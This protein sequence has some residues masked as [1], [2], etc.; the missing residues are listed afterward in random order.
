MVRYDWFCI[1]WRGKGLL[2]KVVHDGEDVVRVVGGCAE[3]GG[4]TR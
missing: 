4:V 3:V 2:L 1:V